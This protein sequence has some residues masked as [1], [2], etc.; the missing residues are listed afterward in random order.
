MTDCTQHTKEN[1]PGND[2]RAN[3]HPNCATCS[4]TKRGEDHTDYTYT[5]SIGVNDETGET[6]V[7]ITDGS[8]GIVGSEIKGIYADQKIAAQIG[9]RIIADL[10]RDLY[11]EVEA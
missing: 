10:R 11:G 1:C 8:G 5:V 4:R 7:L 3:W 6:T 2:K 9:A